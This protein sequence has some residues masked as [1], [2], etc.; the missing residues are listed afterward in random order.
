RPS[1]STPRPPIA[2]RPC[3]AGWRPDDDPDQR[4]LFRAGRRAGGAF[5]GLAG[6]RGAL[7]SA[8]FLPPAVDPP[9][10]Q[11]SFQ[12]SETVLAGSAAARR[13]RRP[14]SMRFMYIVTSPKGHLMPSPGLMEAIGKISDREVKAGRMI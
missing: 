5:V 14:Q 7:K 1:A 12:L 11:S 10:A 8:I 6:G 4:L 2:R 9:Q 13:N 3:S